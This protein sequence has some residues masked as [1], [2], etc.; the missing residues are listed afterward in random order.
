MTTVERRRFLGE[1]SRMS[2]H[3]AMYRFDPPRAALA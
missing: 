2:F 1:T 3:W